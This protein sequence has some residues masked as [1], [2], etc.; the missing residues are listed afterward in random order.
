MLLKAGRKACR[1]KPSADRVF[2][3][4]GTPIVWAHWT[5]GPPES[6][7]PAGFTAGTYINRNVTWWPKAKPLHRLSLALILPAP[8]RRFSVGDVLYFGHGDG[9]F[10]F[11]PALA[12]S[13]QLS[14]PATTSDSHQLRR[15]P[16]PSRH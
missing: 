3:E 2:T 12:A 4:G 6:C 16:E 13:L 7:K 8:A 14:A 1:T 10:R 11:I 9:G 5:H 15:H